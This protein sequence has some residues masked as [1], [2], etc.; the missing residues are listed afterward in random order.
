MQTVTYFILLGSKITVDGDCSHKIKRHLLLGRKAITN[1]YSIL[2]SRDSTLLTKV[3]LVKAMVFP[4][5]M[6]RCESWT[7]KKAEQWRI[8]AF[9]L[10]CWRRLLGVPWTERSFNPKGNQSWTFFGSTDVE[11]ETPILW[12]P[13]GKSWLFGKYPDAGKDRRQ[14]E[15]GTTEDEMV[16]WHHRLDGHDFEQGLGVGDGVGSLVCYSPWSRKES[17]MTEWLKWTEL[18]VFWGFSKNNTKEILMTQINTMVSSLKV[19]WCITYAHKY[20]PL[21]CQEA[22]DSFLLVAQVPFQP[23]LLLELVTGNTAKPLLSCQ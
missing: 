17:D 19:S 7:I 21:R 15:K 9:E 13:G 5:V 12:L 6:Y 4:V 8:D 22:P 16:G 11:A 10:W 1:L 3:R 18:P 14:E 20:N 2:K 23:W